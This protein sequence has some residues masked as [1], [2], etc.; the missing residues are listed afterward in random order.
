MNN[1]H[2]DDDALI[3]DLAA[4]IP[5]DFPLGVVVQNEQTVD[6]ISRG[7]NELNGRGVDYWKTQ[8]NSTYQQNLNGDLLASW[9]LQEMAAFTR[10]TWPHL[11]VQSPAQN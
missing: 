10:A 7:L 5:A 8:L 6:L 1:W 9:I 2:S 4:A 11:S 3:A